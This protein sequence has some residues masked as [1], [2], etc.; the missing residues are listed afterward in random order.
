[1]ALVD[2]ND[3]HVKKILKLILKKFEKNQAQMFI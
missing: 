1:M 2:S 3:T